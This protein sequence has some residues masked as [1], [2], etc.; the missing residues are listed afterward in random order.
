M[1]IVTERNS[2]DVRFELDRAMQEPIFSEFA[3]D[4]MNTLRP[5]EPE[6]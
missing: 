2:M 1:E 4:I 3:T 6:C 5:Q